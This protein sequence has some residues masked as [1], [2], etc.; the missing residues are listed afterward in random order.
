[1]IFTELPL[2][3]VTLTDALAE[4]LRSKEALSISRTIEMVQEKDGVMTH[5]H[6]EEIVRVV[7]MAAERYPVDD[8]FTGTAREDIASLPV[9]RCVFVKSIQELREHISRF[10]AETGKSFRGVSTP[11]PCHYRPL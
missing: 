7:R 10:E 11:R 8:P 1:M 4:Q 6:Q 9:A 5:P 3:G 2:Y